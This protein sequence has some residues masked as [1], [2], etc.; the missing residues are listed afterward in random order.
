MGARVDVGLGVALRTVVGVAESVAVTEAVAVSLGLG[1]AEPTRAADI[2]NALFEAQA[3]KVYLTKPVINTRRPQRFKRQFMVI[4]SVLKP[5][6]SLLMPSKPLQ[7][8]VVYHI[9]VT[10][11][12]RSWL[13]PTAGKGY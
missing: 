4:L 3:D 5:A 2:A 13:P 12:E 10:P 8:S 6:R 11:A 1:V 7:N 9:P